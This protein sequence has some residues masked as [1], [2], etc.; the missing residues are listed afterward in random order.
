MINTMVLPVRADDFI[1]KVPA[2]WSYD[3]VDKAKIYDS[4]GFEI[5]EVETRFVANEI[6]GIL[7]SYNETTRLFK[8][9]ATKLNAAGIDTSIYEAHISLLTE[10]YNAEP[11]KAIESTESA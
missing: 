9:M 6:V 11:P 3:F 7:N 4:C 5:A 8:E 1:K 2:L 10:V